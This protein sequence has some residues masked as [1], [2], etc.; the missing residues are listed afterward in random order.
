M[1]CTYV[2]PHLHHICT[3]DRATAKLDRFLIW[4]FWA[5]W[6]L[7]GRSLMGRALM[8]P[9][10][11]FWAWPLWAPLGPPGPLW[12]GP[13]WAWPLWLP[14]ALKGRALMGQPLMG[15]PGPLWAL[16]M[17]QAL[18]APLGQFVFFPPGLLVPAN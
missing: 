10:G 17:G 2:S 11:P 14:W 3:H 15:L 9:P 13:L 1:L 4:P 6:A 7:M 18:M 12:A 16:L 8:G 5:P